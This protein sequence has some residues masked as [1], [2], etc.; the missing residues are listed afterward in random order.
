MRVEFA[1]A[2]S[3][4]KVQGGAPLPGK[5]NYYIGSD[6]SKWLTGLPTYGAISYSGLYPGVD[7]DY[8]GRDGRLKGTY[9][10]APGADPSQIRWRYTGASDLHMDAAGNLLAALLGSPSDHSV[11][12]SP[13]S[14]I[15]EEAPLAWQEA[16][17]QGRRV[18]VSARYSLSDDGTVGFVVGAYDHTLPLVIDPVLAYSTYL[19]GGSYDV[20]NAIAVDGSGHAYITGDTFSIDFPFIQPLPAQALRGFADIFVTKLAADGSA[21]LSPP[22]WAARRSTASVASPSP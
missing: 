10:L 20:G 15:L 5:V 14:S 7:L 1:G 9:T 16:G 2:A 21:P 19:G 8:S 4:V 17:G 22:T 11:L 18:S 13:Q 6:R 12:D 3:S